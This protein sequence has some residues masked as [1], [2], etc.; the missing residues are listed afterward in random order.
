MWFDSF[1]IP[2]DAPHPDEALAFINFMQRP[3]IAAR[4][5][6]YVYYANGNKD[7]QPF[8]DEDVIDDP[9]I[10][11]DEATLDRLFTSTTYPDKVQR[12]VTRLWTN[13]KTRQLS[14]PGAG[15]AAR[16]ARHRTVETMAAEALGPIRRKFRALD[17]SVGQAVHRVPQR[18]QAL[19][20]F[21]RRRRPL[22]RA[23]TSASSS[24][25]SA[26][27]AAARPR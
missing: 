26:R 9:A 17:R 12:V 1:V 16:R 10:Y 5:S 19:R 25:C 7:S 15:P 6:N 11:P 14:S 18:H 8:L 27:P 23:S 22:P 2:A 13:L 20:R 4:N 24:R 21:H 3:E